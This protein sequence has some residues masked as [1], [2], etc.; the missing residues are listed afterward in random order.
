MGNGR[1]VEEEKDEE[2]LPAWDYVTQSLL[3][4]V[5]MEITSEAIS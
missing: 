4:I 2:K 1:L 5:L 3:V